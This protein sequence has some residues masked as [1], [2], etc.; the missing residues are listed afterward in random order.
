MHFIQERRNFLHFINDDR[1]RPASSCEFGNQQE[2]ILW[3]GQQP[4]LS[5]CIEQ[6]DNRA[7]WVALA[8]PNG[9][10]R[11]A[12]TKKEM[13]YA[14]GNHEEPLDFGSHFSISP[15]KMEKSTPKPIV[16]HPTP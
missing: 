11:T 15:S 7:I 5:L 13:A 4:I 10:P 1:L 9:F 16:S 12:R 3:P 6:I 14:G 8:Q 2:K